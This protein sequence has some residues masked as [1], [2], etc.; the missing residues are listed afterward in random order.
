M[1]L[2]LWG[3]FVMHSMHSMLMRFNMLPYNSTPTFKTRSI[4]RGSWMCGSNGMQN[5]ADHKKK[6]GSVV[7]VWLTLPKYSS[8]WVTIPFMKKKIPVCIIDL[9]VLRFQNYA[10]NTSPLM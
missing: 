3:H 4:M 9:R 5:G 7:E 1:F 10:E 6:Q 8:A 2:A